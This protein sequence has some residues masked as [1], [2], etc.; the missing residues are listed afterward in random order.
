MSIGCRWPRGGARYHQQSRQEMPR[1]NHPGGK[2]STASI[3]GERQQQIQSIMAPQESPG[4]ANNIVRF[5]PTVEPPLKAKEHVR[6]VKKKNLI[7]ES[8]RSQLG[9]TSIRGEQQF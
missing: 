5:D 3:A 4:N 1:K 2:R 9:V 8:S 7:L 6:S